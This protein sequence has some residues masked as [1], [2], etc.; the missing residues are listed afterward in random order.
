M[1]S[2]LD[3]KLK[4]RFRAFLGFQGEKPAAAARKSIQAVFDR[5][6]SN[7]WE[8]YIVG[9][10]LRDI[11]LAPRSIFPRDIDIIIA[12]ATA[13]ALLAT[14]HDL[15]HR[16]T[17]F[18]GLHLIGD[19]SYGGITRSSGHI[20]FDVWR[21]E[22]TWGI[23]HAHLAPT[24]DNFVKTP[25]LNIDS[26]AI[27]LVPKGARRRVVECG[28]FDALVTRTLEINY[29][30]NPYPSVCIVRSLIMA[31]KLQ[32]ALGPNL[33]AYIA[34]HAAN[35]SVDDLLDAQRSHYGE[36][37]CGK[38]EIQGWLA[39][40]TAAVNAGVIGIQLPT[41]SSRQLTLWNNWPP[42]AISSPAPYRLHPS[43]DS[44][45]IQKDLSAITE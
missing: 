7:G 21:L 12:G 36:I 42:T 11:M 32:F 14:F 33:A 37:R 3:R 8:A 26:V 1:D 9:G 18:G 44:N 41:T 23:C 17:R 16:R 30:P 27:E 10:T 19:F 25:F 28:F 6:L 34:A 24:I 39:R 35:G 45:L 5:I 2:M 40:I 29:A 22:D 31:A 38:E 20:Y 43:P 15:L 4:D 13:D